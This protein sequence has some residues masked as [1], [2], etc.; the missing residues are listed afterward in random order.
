MR[1]AIATALLALATASQ[2]GENQ[3]N[4]P[5]GTWAGSVSGMYASKLT[6]KAGR[7]RWSLTNEGKGENVSVTLEGDYSVT[8]DSVVYGIVTKVT[9]VHSGTDTPKGFP[10]EEDTF[11]FRFRVDDD[12]LNVKGLKGK[13]FEDLKRAA[14]RY[15]KQPAPK[16]E[17]T[18]DKEKK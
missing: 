5:Q 6:M 4:D 3:K 13:G 17:G 7:F 1:T 9:L 18:K 10:E 14:G 15:K 2:A 12:E 11:S 16:E 8:K